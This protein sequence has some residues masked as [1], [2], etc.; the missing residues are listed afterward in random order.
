MVFLT[1]SSGFLGREILKKLLA[2]RIA[3]SYSYRR[4]LP[5][6]AE[7]TAGIKADFCSGV[8]TPD[9][10]KGCS[11]IIHC[12]G[13]IQGR[14]QE[15]LEANYLATQRILRLAAAVGVKKIVYISS[16]DALLFNNAYAQSKLKAEESVRKSGLDWVIIRP[17]IIFGLGDN[18]NIALLAK[19]IRWIP[20]VPLPFCGRFCWEPVFVGDLADYIIVSSLD[21]KVKNKAINVVGS[22]KLTFKD[23]VKILSEHHKT[24]TV[25]F[26]I[27]ACAMQVIRHCFLA[28]LGKDKCE[29]IFSAFCDKIVPG[30]SE[31]VYL[32][33]KLGDIYVPA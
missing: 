22:Q 23:I 13:L 14:K 1:G 31:K 10:F 16:I 25:T 18:K 7:A 26:G 28:V 11:V 17:S 24:K 6:G 27:P 19:I 5:E 4:R 21:D 15:L 20:I 30:G 33:T 8:I 9:I 32:K 29:S 12:A 2:Q 3:V